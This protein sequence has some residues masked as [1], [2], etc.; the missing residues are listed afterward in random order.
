MLLSLRQGP[1]TN[2]GTPFCRSARSLARFAAT[3]EEDHQG[4]EHCDNDE[5]DEDHEGLP[6]KDTPESLPAGGV[7]L[8]VQAIRW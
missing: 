3:D 8:L 5:F 4:N 6:G 1:V 2:P 7:V